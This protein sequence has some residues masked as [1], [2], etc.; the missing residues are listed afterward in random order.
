MSQIVGEK[1]N[2]EQLNKKVISVVIPVFNEEA[3]VSRVYM[4]VKTVFE[5]E[6][7][8]KYDFELIFTDNHSVDKTYQ[9]LQKI[10]AND[11]RIRVVRFVRNFG[12]NKSLLTGYCLAR[13]NAAIQLD[14]DLQDS[15]SFF[16]NM[17]SNWELGHDV[18]VGRREKR[19]ENYFLQKARKI[20]YRFLNSIS[21]DNLVIDGGD[22]RLV[23]RS[24]LDK[25]RKTHDATP[26]VR[27]LISSFACNQASFSYER[28][29]RVH[30]KSK[31]PLSRLI[32]LAIDGVTNHSILPL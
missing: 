31:F 6:L 18:V 7:K 14:C 1:T 12:F 20:F 23:D 22:F 8:N 2:E 16:V 4:A 29:T 5:C 28:Q 27:G 15:P 30:G 24:I 3:N 17:L 10:A 21:E 9:E 13:G 19:E 32:E 25:L 11:S 26:Y